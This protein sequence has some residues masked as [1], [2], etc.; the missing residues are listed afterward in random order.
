[1]RIFPCLLLSFSTHL[2]LSQ[3]GSHTGGAEKRNNLSLGN[4]HGE[5][6]ACD[7]QRVAYIH[8]PWIDIYTVFHNQATRISRRNISRWCFDYIL[9]HFNSITWDSLVCLG[10]LEATQ[11]PRLHSSSLSSHHLQAIHKAKLISVVC[12]CECTS[13]LRCFHAAAAKSTAIWK[14]AACCQGLMK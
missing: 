13:K 4:A 10:M 12:K 14:A 9:N 2:H 6:L 5:P 7:F 8:Y 3:P 1:M 11:N